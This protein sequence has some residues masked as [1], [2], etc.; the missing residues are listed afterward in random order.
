MAEGTQK[1]KLKNTNQ[2]AFEEL[3]P[4][5]K[6]KSSLILPKIKYCSIGKKAKKQQFKRLIFANSK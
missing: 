5:F 4:H 1:P 6:F 3:T 2:N